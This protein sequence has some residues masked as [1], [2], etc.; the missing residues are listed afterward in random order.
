[1]ISSRSS[2]SPTRRS[3]ADAADPTPS[4]LPS[5]IAAYRYTP[6]LSAWATVPSSA[7]L[8]AT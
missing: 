7:A 5:D 4:Q 8:I 3:R 2:S 6:S 1:M